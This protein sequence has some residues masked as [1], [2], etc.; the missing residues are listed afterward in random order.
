MTEHHVDK[1]AYKRFSHALYGRSEVAKYC[2]LLQDNFKVDVNLLL[3]LLYQAQCETIVEARTIREIITSCAKFRIVFLQPFRR[4]RKIASIHPYLKAKFLRVELQLE[5]IAM[6]K[7]F[8]AWLSCKPTDSETL[9]MA[10]AV[11]RNLGNYRQELPNSS[12][13]FACEWLTIHMKAIA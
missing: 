12:C 2:L 3:F 11:Q 8:N 4:F 9:P 6:Q 5:F 1:A 10:I 7:I 13:D